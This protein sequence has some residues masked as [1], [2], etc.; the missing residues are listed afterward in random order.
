[1]AETKRA[2]QKIEDHLINEGK[3]VKEKQAKR[4]LEERNHV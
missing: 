2:G 4:D 3:R 1:M